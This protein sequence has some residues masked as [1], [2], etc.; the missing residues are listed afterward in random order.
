V[1]AARP[2]PCSTARRCRVGGPPTKTDCAR[3]RPHRGDPKCLRFRADG[4]TS[5]QSFQRAVGSEA[6]SKESCEHQ[7]FRRPLRAFSMVPCNGRG[8]RVVIGFIRLI[9][10]FDVRTATPVFVDEL[11]AR[12]RRG[13]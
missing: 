12:H 4:R 3:T 8:R 6:V 13:P 7:F 5:L 11:D 2:V 10:Y 9:D 1:H